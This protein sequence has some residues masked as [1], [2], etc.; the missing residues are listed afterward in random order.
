MD[1]LGCFHLLSIVNN[2]AVSISVQVFAGNQFSVLWDIY[3][4]AGLLDHMVF[5]FN[6]LRNC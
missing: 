6:L 3:V 5:L 2:V 4:G 1:I